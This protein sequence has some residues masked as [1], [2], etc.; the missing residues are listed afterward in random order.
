MKRAEMDRAS[1]ERAEVKSQLVAFPV[2]GMKIWLLAPKDAYRIESHGVG[3][4][5]EGVL[6]LKRHIRVDEFGRPGFRQKRISEPNSECFEEVLGEI[7]HWSTAAS[8]VRWEKSDTQLVERFC[9]WV[10][11]ET[12]T[13]DERDQVLSFVMPKAEL[14]I[15]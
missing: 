12:R 11:D 2:Y 4:K 1:L 14:A 8:Q 6:W 5:S 13:E 3:E 9:D 15:A 7:G 10:F